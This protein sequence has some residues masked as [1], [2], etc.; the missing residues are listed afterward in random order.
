MPRV[1]PFFT[2][3]TLL[4]RQG[5]VL[6]HLMESTGWRLSRGWI[7]NIDGL[8]RIAA[9]AQKYGC[10]GYAPHPVYEVTA[11]CNLR[12]IHCHAKEVSRILESSTLRGRGGL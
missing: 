2:P 12:C 6:L 11:L 8:V 10:F 4:A 5:L 3:P 7:R 9:G 1:R